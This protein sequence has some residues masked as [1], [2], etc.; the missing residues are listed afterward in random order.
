MLLLDVP[1]RASFSISLLVCFDQTTEAGFLLLTK[2]PMPLEDMVGLDKTTF[3]ILHS[4]FICFP[5][6]FASNF[7]GHTDIPNNF[8]QSI[9]L[10]ARTQH[11]KSTGTRWALFLLTGARNPQ[12][13]SLAV[14]SE[15]LLYQQH[16][17]TL[18]TSPPKRCLGNR[19]SIRTPRF[20]TIFR[21]S[22]CLLSLHSLRPQ[23][24]SRKRNT[25]NS[26]CSPTIPH[27]RPNS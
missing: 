21:F 9:R 13:P 6:S 10:H 17:N 15:H 22:E 18:L 1:Q 20:N 24:R 26:P 3:C 25:C 2:S 16:S 5:L 27:Q 8:S 12:S 19:N 4:D 14:V 11:L 23:R 7:C